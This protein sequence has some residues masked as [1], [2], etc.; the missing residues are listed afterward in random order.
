MVDKAGPKSESMVKTSPV[1]KEQLLRMGP[2]PNYYHG[3]W[4]GRDPEDDEILLDCYR[5]DPYQI[6][7]DWPYRCEG[8][9]FHNNQDCLNFAWE[10]SRNQQY[11]D[12]WIQSPT[13]FPQVTNWWCE[14]RMTRDGTWDAQAT[15]LLKRKQEERLHKGEQ[16]ESI[17]THKI[18]P[19]SRAEANGRRKA[20]WDPKLKKTVVTEE[21]EAD[22]DSPTRK[23]QIEHLKTLGI[24]P[25]SP[26]A[27]LAKNQWDYAVKAPNAS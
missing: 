2:V 11:R 23:R 19:P 18:D 6:Y 21:Y 25:T 3:E 10:L 17:A 24:D 14:E 9:V 4:V 27:D 15:E 13:G 26:E 8:V 5:E 7:H 12:V 20:Y 1:T 16:V 22:S